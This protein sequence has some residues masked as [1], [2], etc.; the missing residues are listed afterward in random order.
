LDPCTPSISE[1]PRLKDLDKAV[2]GDAVKSFMKVKLENNGRAAPAVA[3]IHQVYGI[4]KIVCNA[5]ALH[6]TRLIRGDEGRD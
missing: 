1:P 4:N 2:L 6:E 5:T 3:T